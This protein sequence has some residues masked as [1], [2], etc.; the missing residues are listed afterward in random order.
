MK[1][2]LTLFDIQ[3]FGGIMDDVEFLGRGF[4]EAGHEC[5][6]IYLR[7]NARMPS[8][9]RFQKAQ[10]GDQPSIYGG[11]VNALRGW[12]NVQVY[13]YGSDRNIELLHRKFRRYD[14]I[15]HEIPNPKPDPEGWWR[16]IYHSDVNQ[17]IAAHD[18]HFRDMYP[19]ISE[20]AP[21]VTAI[22]C[23]NHAG[24]VGLEHCPIP[25]AFIG[26]AH[27]L[28]EWQEHPPIEHRSKDAVCAHVWKAWKHND[29]VVAA[30]PLMKRTRLD[31]AGDG[32]EGRYMRSETKVKP[33][34]AGLWDAFMGA[35]N[36]HYHGLLDRENLYE[37]YQ[38]SKVMIDLSYSKKFAALGNHF[39]RSILEAANNGCISICTTENM[40]ENNPQ[41]VLFKDNVT[42]IPV[43]Q[44]LA[45]HELAEVTDWATNDMHHDD[46]MDMVW[47]CRKVLENHF[48]YRKTCLQYL[49]LAKGK[50]AGIYP[51][52]ET[53]A[54]PL[55][56][57]P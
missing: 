6:L 40:H 45:P 49:E 48:D 54:V 47:E 29:I 39:N 12:D 23:T 32:I 11:T 10:G 27:E 18:A 31:M 33:K 50:P 55:Q 25:R 43:N 3:D 44:G 46:H 4:R 24:Y 30:G 36:C 34:Y 13:G 19:H 16:K 51:V 8:T 52:L 21:Y 38:H 9:R 35:P 22:T 5:D 53:G 14:L 7:N 15:I 1:I 26:A 2:L 41:V 57:A 17:I 28:Q 56:A 20:L 42:H 37:L